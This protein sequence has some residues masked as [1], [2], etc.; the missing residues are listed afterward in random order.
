MK[1]DG[2]C[3]SEMLVDFQQ[4]TH[5]VTSLNRELF[6]VKNVLIFTPFP[7]MPPWQNALAIQISFYPSQ[8][9]SIDVDSRIKKKNAIKSTYVNIIKE[10]IWIG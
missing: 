10:N 1:M 6:E 3:S 2:T 8:K 7:Q 9:Y 4:T 5:Y